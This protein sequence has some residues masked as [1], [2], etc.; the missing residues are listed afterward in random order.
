MLRPLVLLFAVAIVAAP[1]SPA[2]A[3]QPRRT[4][5]RR[6]P[7]SVA[8]PRIPTP[9]SVLGFEPGEDRKLAEWPLLVRYYQAL[10]KAS[11]RVQ[12]RELGKT[13]LGAP[14]VVLVISSPQNLRRLNRFRTLNARLAD[15]RTLRSTRE[16]EEA[17]RDGKTVVL[18]TSGIHS[19]EVGGHLTPVVL[20]H[21]LA[22]DT[23]APPPAIPDPLILLLVPALNPDGVTIVTRW[24][25]R[26]LGTP[27]EGTEPPE[28]YHHYAG[29][30]NNRDWYAFTQVETRLA[31]DSLYNV[32]HPQIVQD[33]HQQ[34]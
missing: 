22:T 23:S 25:N 34:D 16:T 6:R 5:P 30:D 4:P 8:A 1:A 28:L 27:A 32:W 24:Y 9:K 17:L 20:A 29:H 18:I 13:T 10:A 2:A 33:I 21:R 3:Q 15:P 19:T 14:F 7:P 26:T 31:V 11:D 12:Y